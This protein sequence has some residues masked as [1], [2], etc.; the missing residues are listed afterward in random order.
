MKTILSVIFVYLLHS[1]SLYSQAPGWQWAKKGNGINSDY[2][3]SV[4]TDLTGNVILAGGFISPT[5]TFGSTTLTNNNS[6][7]T[8]DFFL[9]KYDPSGNV[10]WAVRAGGSVD[11]VALDVACDDTG[12]IYVS[13]LFNSPTLILGPD[14]L[15][16]Q[17]FTDIFVVKFGPAGNAV[18]ARSAGGNSYDE[19]RSIALDSAGNIYVA[20]MFASATINFGTNPLTNSN[21]ATN[22]LYL[23]KYDPA[24][25]DL[26]ATNASASGYESAA[27]VAIDKYDDPV[28]TGYYQGSSCTFGSIVLTNISST[29][30]AFVAKYSSSGTAIWANDISSTGDESGSGIACDTAGNVYATGVFYGTTLVLGTFTLTNN[31]SVDAYV[32]KYNNAGS[33][34]WATLFGGTGAD[35]AQGVVSDKSGSLYLIGNFQSNTPIV[36]GNDTLFPLNAQWDPIYVLKYD[37]SGNP[38]WA[39]QAGGL[40]NYDNGI[41]IALDTSNTIYVAGHFSSSSI[42]FGSNNM[43]LTNNS[44]GNAGDVF[45]AK[46]ASCLSIAPPICMVT[47]DSLSKFNVIMWDKTSYTN[48]D[49]FIIYREITTNNYQRLAAV[50][51]S[52]LSQ[53]VD[54]VATLYFPNTGNPNSGTYRYKLQ[55]LDTCG[56]LSTLGNYHNTIYMTNNSGTFSWPQLYTIEGGPNPVNAYVLMRDDLNTG[57]WQAIN[58]VAGTQQSVTDPAYNAWVA[59]ANWRVQTLWSISCTPTLRF[60]HDQTSSFNTSLSNTLISPVGTDELSDMIITGIYP[61]PASSDL[62]IKFNNAAKKEIRIRN[63]TGECLRILTLKQDTFEL[64]VGSLMPGVYFVEVVSQHGKCVKKFIKI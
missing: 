24:G 36:F 58:S 46:I 49:S 2:G 13:G 39:M 23:V 62:T 22:D 44:L 16:N 14:T 11:D 26:W 32:V 19:G 18:W 8:E 30:D 52:A 6:N 63:V 28:I 7:I 21:N 1:L 53:F 31:G 12:N 47:A 61:N 20:G 38:A 29:P 9:V 15:I 40:D 50:P 48:V 51:Y 33:V 64:N 34:T 4:T 5:I 35:Y 43:N 57:N 17:A 42:S 60:N 54:T 41:S 56:N 25:T 45:V 37:N 10:I 27:A 3:R 59:T 55:I